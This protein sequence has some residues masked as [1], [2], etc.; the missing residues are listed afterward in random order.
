MPGR[1]T[2]RIRREQPDGRLTAGP[3][4]R[5]Q[6]EPA[7]ADTVPEPQAATGQAREAA[8]D[9]AQRVTATGPEPAR[10][11]AG[12]RAKPIGVAAKAMR[13]GV[14][15]LPRAATHLRPGVIR[16]RRVATPLR[17]AA[18]LRVAEGSTVVAV[19]EDS[20]AA[21]VDRTVAAVAVNRHI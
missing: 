4:I 12:L 16:L 20:T 10:A 7:A 3:I 13:T 11:I 15:R 5:R 9:R 17:H 21:A 19:V 2:T 14:T 1:T 8:I 18:T 6:T